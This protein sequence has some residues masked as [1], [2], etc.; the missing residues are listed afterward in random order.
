MWLKFAAYVAGFWAAFH[1]IFDF[2]N[3]QAFGL[4]LVISI[5]I[6]L[7]ASRK[8]PASTSFRP[9]MFAIFPY[10][11]CMLIDLGL[12]TDEEFKVITQ[13][14]PPYRPWS[15]RHLFHYQIRAFV[16]SREPS[17][18]SEVIHFPDLGYYLAKLDVEIKLD[19]FERPVAP[20]DRPG[21]R[22]DWAPEFF[23]R[24]WSKG[25]HFGIRVPEDWWKENKA[26]VAADTVLHED[27]EYNFGQVRLTL[28]ILPYE[29]TQEFYI[30]SA[31]GHQDRV[32]EIV[33]KYGWK[34]EALGGGE[35]LYYGEHYEHKYVSVRTNDLE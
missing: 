24:G 23:M 10:V 34:N 21:R 35:L 6:D 1:F 5:A 18:Q 14:V 28:A 4:G 27:H 12:T 30:P 17:T 32:K 3:L 26:K 22:P 29:S 2:P 33:G 31:P 15:D 20:F 16:I 19:S 7:G 8:G 9:Y 11:G 25:Y 13:D